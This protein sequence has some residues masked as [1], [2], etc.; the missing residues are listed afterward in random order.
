MSS[1]QVR[2]HNLFLGSRGLLL[3]ELA[4]L[5]DALE[6]A[7]AVLVDL[8]LGDLDLGGR[9][10]DGHALAVGLLAGDTLDV[11]DVFETVDG[12]DLALAALVGATLDDDLVVLAEGDGAD[13]RLKSVWRC[14]L[15]AMCEL[16]Y[17]VLLSELCEQSVHNSWRMHSVCTYPWKAARS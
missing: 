4:A 15:L 6:D 10:A 12:N 16:A 13:L 11:Y 2:Y 3:V 5:G 1:H 14:I 8:E 17:V 7:L 9:D